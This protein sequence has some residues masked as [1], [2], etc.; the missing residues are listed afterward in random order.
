MPSKCYLIYT[1]PL[2]LIRNLWHGITQPEAALG[3]T[4]RVHS[5]CV[6]KATCWERC[7]RQVANFATRKWRKER[8]EHSETRK[9]LHRFSCGHHSDHLTKNTGLVCLKGPRGSQCEPWLPS[10]HLSP[11]LAVSGSPACWK[12]LTILT[13]TH[14]HTMVGLAPC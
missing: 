2:N 6:A 5:G 12:V 10:S 3:A 13:Y 14:I 8:T 1:S 9:G 11:L 7:G 4:L